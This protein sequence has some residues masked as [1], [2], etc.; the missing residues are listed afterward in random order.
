LL[1]I[2][3]DNVFLYLAV[4]FYY[5]CVNKSRAKVWDS[6]TPEERKNYLKTTKDE[7]NKHLDFRFTY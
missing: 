6:W 7:G 1:A 3:V 5:A 4:N 2:A